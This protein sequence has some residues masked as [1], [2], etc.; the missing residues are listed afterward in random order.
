MLR[1]GTAIAYRLDS[2]YEDDIAQVTRNDL[3]LSQVGVG[4]ENILIPTK[5]WYPPQNWT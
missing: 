1:S 3:M 4:H 2:L 5:F